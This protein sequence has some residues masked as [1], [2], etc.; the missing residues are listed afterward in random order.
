MSLGVIATVTV[1]W[2]FNN[3]KGGEIWGDVE[4]SRERADG[5][6]DAANDNAAWPER[7]LRFVQEIAA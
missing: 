5:T 6:R 2:I 3:S 7:A 1:T 4:N